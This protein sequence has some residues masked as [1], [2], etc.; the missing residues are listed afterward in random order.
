MF[1]PISRDYGIEVGVPDFFV[2]LFQNP[3]YSVELIL[4]GAPDLL[5]WPLRNVT[6]SEYQPMFRGTAGFCSSTTAQLLEWQH[7]VPKVQ[8]RT[9]ST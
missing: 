1:L 8:K 2:R 9:N 4:I 3:D 5:N 6:G 7:A